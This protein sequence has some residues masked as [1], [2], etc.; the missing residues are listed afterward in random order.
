[1]WCANPSVIGQLTPWLVVGWVL[2]LSIPCHAA[3]PPDGQLEAKLD[4]CG[5]EAL[6]PFPWPV[7]ECGQPGFGCPLHGPRQWLDEQEGKVMTTWTYQG[8]QGRHHGRYTTFWRIEVDPCRALGI[9][10]QTGSGRPSGLYSFIAA[11]GNAPTLAEKEVLLHQVGFQ[12]FEPGAARHAMAEAGWRKEGDGAPRV[13]EAAGLE[14]TV[15]ALP[16]VV[17]YDGPPVPQESAWRSVDE[18][19]PPFV[20]DDTWQTWPGHEEFA[21]PAF[22]VHRR[23]VDAR[24]ARFTIWAIRA[25]AISRTLVFESLGDGDTTRRHAVIDYLEDV[26][27]Y[28]VIAGRADTS[29]Q[30]PQSVYP[31]DA[32]DRDKSEETIAP[33]QGMYLFALSNENGWIN[34]FDDLLALSPDGRAWRIKLD[35]YEAWSLSSSSFTDEGLD[36]VPWNPNGEDTDPPTHI[37]WATLLPLL[38]DEEESP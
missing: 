29:L 10:E 8:G 17:W 35:D 31:P 11:A 30:P 1:M 36:L 13:V 38:R 24:A 27:P 9:Q 6:S 21:G 19:E 32:L 22:I 4:A 34:Y 3:D 20:E 14:L 18:Y 25:R 23:L 12:P 7:P 16:P 26:E 28:P 15:Q 2:S 5:A 33:I 37:P